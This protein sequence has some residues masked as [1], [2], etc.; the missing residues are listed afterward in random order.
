MA[1]RAATQRALNVRAM[2]NITRQPIAVTSV[3]PQS[4]LSTGEVIED[5]QI[6]DY[7]NLPRISAQERGPFG[8][9]DPQDK[10]NFGEPVSFLNRSIL[11]IILTCI[12]FYHRF[13]K[14]MKLWVSGLLTF[15]PTVLIRLLLNLLLPLVS[16]VVL[17]LLFTRLIPKALL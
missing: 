7:P 15:I 2:M 13:M 5:P 8:W 9:D 17:L 6:G 4:T 14:K 12:F 16:L 1:F 3:R 11:Y 10:R